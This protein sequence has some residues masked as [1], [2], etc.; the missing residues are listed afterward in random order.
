MQPL[1]T[2]VWWVEHVISTGGFHLG[3]ANTQ[4]MYWFTYYSID[5]IVVILF[6]ILALVWIFLR[7]LKFCC[8]SNQIDNKPKTKEQ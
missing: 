4:E 1:D 7:L 8:K 2:A 5:S 3:N 6:V